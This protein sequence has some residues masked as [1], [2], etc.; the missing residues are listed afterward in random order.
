MPGHKLLMDDEVEVEGED[1]A[2]IHEKVY[3]LVPPKG[4]TLAEPLQLEL[5]VTLLLEPLG[6]KEGG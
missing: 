2:E 5:Q 4:E 3:G 6:I 1:D